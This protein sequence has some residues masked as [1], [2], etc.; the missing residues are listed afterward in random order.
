MSPALHPPERPSH[1]HT[2]KPGFG[3]RGHEMNA[4]VCQ[5]MKKLERTGASLKTQ[6]KARSRL[7]YFRH[8]NPISKCS[9]VLER[10]EKPC[11]LLYSLE[12]FF[13]KLSSLKSHTTLLAETVQLTPSRSTIAAAITEKKTFR[14][15]GHTCLAWA[16]PAWCGLH[17]PGMGSTGFSPWHR[18]HVWSPPP[19]GQ[20]GSPQ[21]WFK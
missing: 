2:P 20:Y 17:L 21:R 15:T 5:I 18:L 7:F 10:L 9:K 11:D 12:L 4:F 14:P 6:P 19:P 16:P 1:T 8:S 3:G 13:N